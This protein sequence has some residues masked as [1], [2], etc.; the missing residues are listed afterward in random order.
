MFSDK[1]DNNVLHN[2]LITPFTPT[3]PP[4]AM[5]AAVV[6]ERQRGA[7]PL[8]SQP[9]VKLSS[10][11]GILLNHDEHQCHV[12]APPLPAPSRFV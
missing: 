2:I 10:R 4:C 8:L 11:L 3:F 7:C 9:L 6:V 12:V 5:A 1:Q